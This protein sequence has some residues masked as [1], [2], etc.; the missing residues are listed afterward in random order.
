MSDRFDQTARYTARSGTEAENRVSFSSGGRSSAWNRT[1]EGQSLQISTPKGLDKGNASTVQ[2]LRG[3]DM[4]AESDP[5][6]AAR[7]WAVE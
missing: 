2:P 5:G 6:C 3:R 7:P 1:I 4:L